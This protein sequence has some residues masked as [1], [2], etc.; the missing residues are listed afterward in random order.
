MNLCEPFCKNINFWHCSALEYY[1][2]LIISIGAVF[3]HPHG[4]EWFTRIC[5]RAFPWP[6]IWWLL[7]DGSCNA[8]WRHFECWELMRIASD[9]QHGSLTP[10]ASAE[11]K[12]FILRGWEKAPMIIQ[13]KYKHFHFFWGWGEGVGLVLVG[14]LGFFLKPSISQGVHTIHTIVFKSPSKILFLQI[15]TQMRTVV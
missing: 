8:S 11:S 3:W 14:W 15:I 10:V 12:L 9:T 2:T 13:F 7:F 1:S 4:N 5:C 6:E